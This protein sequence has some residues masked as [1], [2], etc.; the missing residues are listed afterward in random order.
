MVEVDLK[1][2][3]LVSLK[4]YEATVSSKLWH[5]LLLLTDK[6]K[7]LNA[8]VAFFGATPQGGGVALMRHAILR[9]AK[10]LELPI[11]WFVVKPKPEI[12]A[13]TK[14]GVS[15]QRLPFP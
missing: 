15:H 1:Y 5:T 4:D 13:V 12:F 14:V 7:K 9:L 8:R 6:A 2:I 10:L 11:S 3:K